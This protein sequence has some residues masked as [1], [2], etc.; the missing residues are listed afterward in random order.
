MLLCRQI[1]GLFA[2]LLLSA[3][4]FEP[5]YVST[6]AG[7]SIRNNFDLMAPTDRGTYQF[8]HDL[9]GQ[10][11]DNPQGKYALSYSISKNTTNAAIDADGRSHRSLLKGALDY[12]ITSKTTGDTVTKNR[13]V[14]FTSYSALAS[15]V[16]SNASGRDATKR[17]MKILSDNLVDD[18]MLAAAKGEI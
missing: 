8:Y 3:C 13:I 6:N 4:G 17:L 7:K 5:A 16:A 11:S 1:S 18:L 12:K 10:I 15:S 9:K 2:L 14:G